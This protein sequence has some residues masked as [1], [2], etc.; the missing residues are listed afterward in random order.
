MIRA[1]LVRGVEISRF[2]CRL[3]WTDHHSCRIGTQIKILPIENLD[4]DDMS[5]WLRGV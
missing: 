2:S 5:F 1:R 3:E 4:A